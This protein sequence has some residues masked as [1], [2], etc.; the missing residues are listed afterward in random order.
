MPV[1]GIEPEWPRLGAGSAAAVM[2]RTESRHRLCA[3]LHKIG[4]EES[5]VATEDWNC[6]VHGT[7]TA[8]PSP[9]LYEEPI[10]DRFKLMKTTQD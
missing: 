1:Y 6:D 7:R 3:E 4:T 2:P 9:A 5:P 8:V 10:I